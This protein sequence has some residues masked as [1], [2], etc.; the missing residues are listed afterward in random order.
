M[1]LRLRPGRHGLSTLALLTFFVATSAR[2]LTA[3]AGTEACSV[4]VLP[5][6]TSAFDSVLMVGQLT[7]TELDTLMFEATREEPDLKP[8]RPILRSVV[9]QYGVEAVARSL[10]ELAHFGYSWVGAANRGRAAA[11]FGL[12]HSLYPDEISAEPLAAMLLDPTYPDELR[13]GL[14]V[15]TTYVP[16]DL[17]ELEL[18]LETLLCQAM[19]HVRPFAL[20]PRH[21]DVHSPFDRLYWYSSAVRLLRKTVEASA[22]RPNGMQRIQER[23]RAESNRIMADQISRWADDARL[24]PQ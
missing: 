17:S 10:L 20:E 6:A 11:A 21:L 16:D 7:W 13:E 3:Q 19:L 1:K 12:L 24:V 15:A 14:A 23:I 8:L 4:P 18:A 9:S 22:L 2:S 5:R